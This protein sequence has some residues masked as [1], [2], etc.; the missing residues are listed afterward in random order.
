MSFLAYDIG[1]LVLFVLVLAIL[2]YVKRKNFKWEGILL[3]YRTN[4]GVKFIDKFAKKYKSMISWMRYI[5]VSMGFLLMIA[6]TYFLMQLLYIF[7]KYPA[8]VR[9]IKVPP[10]TPLIPY[11][12]SIFK[13]DFLPPFYFTYWI[14]AIASIAIFHEA[15]HGILARYSNVKV[16]ST[17][18]GFLGPFLAAFVEPDEKQMEKKDNFSQMAILSAGTFANILLTVIFFLMLIIFFILTFSQAGATF[19]DYSYSIVNT[20][21]ITLINNNHLI[22]NFSQFLD[23]NSSITNITVNNKTYFASTAALSGANNSSLIKVYDNA[24]AFNAQLRGII[25]KINN[26]KI[27]NYTD[28]EIFKKYKPG[29]SILIE[30]SNA[31]SI[32]IYNITLAQNPS[33]NSQPYLGIVLEVRQSRGV[34]GKLV[35]SISSFKQ[36]GVYYSPRFDGE[37]IIFI[38]NL[39]WWL[40]I[41]NL[42]VA[43]I[44][45][46]PLG[47]FDGGK[48]FYLTMFSITK[49][50]KFAQITFKLITYINILIFILLMVFWAFS[51]I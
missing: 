30:T 11:L 51:F 2:F 13:L 29:D 25:V 37:L 8:T 10:L 1:F 35:N 28:L 43:L 31:T 46:L 44:N 23:L 36:Q 32:R 50:K 39:L 24:P 19:S 27:T 20:S 12:P 22:G 47:I 4:I 33:N 34:L 49:S 5:I 38:Y 7:I 18:F 9:A 26:D 48:F 17:G 15:A 16:K 14:I 41:I 42:S 6:M 45:M 40:V 21:S 3:L